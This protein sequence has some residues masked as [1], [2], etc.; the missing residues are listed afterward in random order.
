MEEEKVLNLNKKIDTHLP[1]PKCCC[2]QVDRQVEPFQIL[3]S[4][5]ETTTAI[6]NISA[7]FLQPHTSWHTYTRG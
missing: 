2:P 7:I 6:T 4:C 3:S 1:Y 5:T